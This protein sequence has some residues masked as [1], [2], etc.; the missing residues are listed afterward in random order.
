MFKSLIT[1][2]TMVRERK[3]YRFDLKSLIL[4]AIQERDENFE[5]MI[6]VMSTFGT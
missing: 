2:N 4:I 1:L 3:K 5:K 6:I